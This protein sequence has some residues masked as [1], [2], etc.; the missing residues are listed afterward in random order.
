MEEILRLIIEAGKKGDT[1]AQVDAL[2]KWV[3]AAD[4]WIKQ[5]FFWQVFLVVSIA[6][7]ILIHFYLTGQLIK[8]VERLE[9]ESAQSK[10]SKMLEAA[11]LKK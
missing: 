2:Q 6:V 8:R 9:K 4:H 1:Q 3:V 10:E 7:V 11:G 5:T